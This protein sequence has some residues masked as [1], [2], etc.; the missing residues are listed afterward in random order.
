MFAIDK[1]NT[2]DIYLESSTPF[3]SLSFLAAVIAVRYDIQTLREQTLPCDVSCFHGLSRDD[4][5]CS[6][7]R[8]HAA[9]SRS[10][11]FA[12]VIT[13]VKRVKSLE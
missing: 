9:G 8:S 12:I 13:V 11:L 6:Q 2:F 5:C 10:T 1:I 3:C 7:Q 4:E